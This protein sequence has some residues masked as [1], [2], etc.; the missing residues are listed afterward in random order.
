[1]DGLERLSHTGP[2]IPMTA[3]SQ[4]YDRV[5]TAPMTVCTAYYGCTR[6]NRSDGTSRNMVYV[7]P[8][9][10]LA[11]GYYISNIVPLAVD[12]GGLDVLG[13]MNMNQLIL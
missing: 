9:C 2:I 7:H 11:S 6:Q 3:V 1:M 8:V 10:T 13:D 4:Q 12:R 5:M